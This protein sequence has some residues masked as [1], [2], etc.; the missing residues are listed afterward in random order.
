MQNMQYQI[1]SL[2][3]VYTEHSLNTVQIIKYS[4]Q[5]INTQYTV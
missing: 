2:W 4:V 3:Y 1:H 5:G